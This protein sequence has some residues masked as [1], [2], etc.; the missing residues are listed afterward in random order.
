M[1]QFF[2]AFLMMFCL[3]CFAQIKVPAD[4]TF[5]TP[6]YEAE[7]K[8]IVFSPKPNDKDFSLG[9]PYFDP[10]AGYTYKYLGNLKDDNGNLNFVPTEN[11]I[12]YRWENMD[13]K[14]AVLSD[15]RIKEFK[16]ENPPEFL[17]F[18]KSGKPEKD[19]LV[20]KLSFL[21]GAGFSNLALLQL[22]Q[23]R[24]ENYKSGKFY[25]ELAFAYNALDQSSKAEE[26]VNE[27]EKNGF[28]NELLIKEMHYALLHQNKLIP[29]AD[30]L[31]NNFKNFKSKFYKSEG[32]VNQISNFSKSKDVKN[33]QKWIGLYKKEIGED[34]YKPR[35]DDVEKRLKDIK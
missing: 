16:L 17:K 23:L 12:I 4:F 20:D 26:V 22:E 32:I 8:Y 24:K 21:N 19:L 33:A 10:S 28:R 13:M 30:Y 6:F 27:A 5:T 9:V 3:Q 14:V 2:S 11:G 7:N 18:Y 35:V 34:Q 31:E 29:A 25:F 1:K 15:Q